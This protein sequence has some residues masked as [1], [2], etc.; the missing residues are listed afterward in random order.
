MVREQWVVYLVQC[1]DDS[2]YCGVTNDLEARLTAHNAGRGAKYTRTRL[3]VKLA[4][5]SA[6]MSKR[7]AFLLEYRIKRLPAAEKRGALAAERGPWPP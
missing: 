1:A 3:P 6:A 7:D 2:L 5:V 4:G